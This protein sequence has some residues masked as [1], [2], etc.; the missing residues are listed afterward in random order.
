MIAEIL[1]QQLL[2]EGNA[3]QRHDIEAEVHDLNEQKQNPEITLM[4]GGQ[5]FGLG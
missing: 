4:G 1:L 5:L 2:D 3:R